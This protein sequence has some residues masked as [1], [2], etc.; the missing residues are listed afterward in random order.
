MILFLNVSVFKFDT[1]SMTNLR[2]VTF[3]NKKIYNVM[4]HANSPCELGK[5]FERQEKRLL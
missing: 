5:I 1:V 2:T 4:K 3:L